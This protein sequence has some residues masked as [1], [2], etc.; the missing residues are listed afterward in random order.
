MTIIAPP[1]DY[2]DLTGVERKASDMDLII[3]MMSMQK[4]PHQALAI[5]GAICTTAGA[6]LK[7]TIFI[8]YCNSD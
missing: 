8:Q 3:R 2:T 4:K 5:T 1:M 7:D 6:F